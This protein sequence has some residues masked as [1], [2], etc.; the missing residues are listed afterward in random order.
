MRIS[1]EYN[2]NKNNVN[3]GAKILATNATLEAFKYRLSIL[4]G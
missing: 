2:N 4:A 1:T 3:F